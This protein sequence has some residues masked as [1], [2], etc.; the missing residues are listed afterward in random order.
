[1]CTVSV[2]YEFCWCNLCVLRVCVVCPVC[3]A[4]GFLSVVG[5]CDLCVLF[6][7]WLSVSGCHVCDVR[8]IVRVTF[9]FC[10]ATVVHVM[11]AVWVLCC[12]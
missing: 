1:M 7:E 12:L 3:L 11:G 2:L 8:C 10:A 6:L 9:W 5:D 4:Y